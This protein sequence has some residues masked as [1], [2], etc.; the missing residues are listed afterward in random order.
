[1]T[2]ECLR[3]VI[4]ET[5][6]VRYEFLVVDNQSSDGP[7]NTI[8]AEFPDIRLIRSQR[9]F[10]FAR[11]NNV[12]ALE[13]KGK[14]ILLLNPDTVVIERAIDRIVK[15]AE[16]PP[17]AGIWGRRTL[18]G[19]RTLDPISCLGR[20]ILWNFFCRALGLSAA[21]SSGAQGGA[22]HQSRSHDH[23][24]RQRVRSHPRGDA[25]ERAPG[26]DHDHP[27]TLAGGSSMAGRGALPGQPVGTGR[28]PL[29]RRAHDP[30]RR[31]HGEG[32]AL[33]DGPE[34][35]GRV[36]PDLHVAQGGSR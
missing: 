15:F 25:G 23:P 9:N 29:R 7:A 10:G 17:D 28:L 14:H 6:D 5:R 12:A 30:Q 8:V 26:Q 18:N 1:M 31:R 27:P 36:A 19:D 3:F 34:Q 24:P 11:G 32:A 21:F 13:A 16:E 33:T 4:R 35:P 20:M 2:L 22:H